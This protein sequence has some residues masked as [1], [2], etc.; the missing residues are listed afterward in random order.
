[1]TKED[2]TLNL[3]PLELNQLLKICY[4]Q[5]AV[6]DET[7]IN[8]IAKINEAL[9]AQDAMHNALGGDQLSTGQK[10]D[11]NGPKPLQGRHLSLIV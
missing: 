6:T 10:S 11:Q 7:A 4:E 2:C 5:Q 9:L 8:L 1:M 3:N